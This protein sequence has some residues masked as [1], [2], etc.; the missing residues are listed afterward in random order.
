MY[1][2]FH[3]ANAASTYSKWIISELIMSVLCNGVGSIMLIYT[4][5]TA[6]A[7]TLWFVAFANGAFSGT[8]SIGNLFRLR[9]LLINFIKRKQ[10]YCISKHKSSTQKNM[11]AAI[12]S[13]GT[14]I[15]T[16][17]LPLHKTTERKNHR[18]ERPAVSTLPNAKYYAEHLSSESKRRS[19]TRAS[20]KKSF[21]VGDTSKTQ[22]LKILIQL[23]D[24]IQDEE[25]TKFE[26]SIKKLN[27]MLCVGSPILL[28]VLVITLAIAFSF[29][30]EGK[31]SFS[32][33]WN[34][35]LEQYNVIRDISGWLSLLCNAFPQWYVLFL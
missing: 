24:Q 28:S 23:N 33:T 7:S 25:D 29:L 21:V 30:F 17:T 19:E 22:S 27:A 2:S 34:N 18:L 9:S 1:T 16:S 8:L 10:S 20:P 13:G 26:R 14:N 11:R 31:N 32:D 4:N 6:W 12:S 5:E 35:S 3:M 15:S